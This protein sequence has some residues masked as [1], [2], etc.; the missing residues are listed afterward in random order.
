MPAKCKPN[1]QVLPALCAWLLLI[2]CTA[3]FFAC[4]SS[5]LSEKH[6]PVILI[7][8]AVVSLFV[9]VNFAMATFMDPGTFPRATE[10]E[11]K[12]GGETRAPLYKSI[13]V[14]GMSIRM[15]WCS[16]CQFY[17]PPRCS[18]C[19][20]CNACIEVFDH[21]CPWVNN[22]IGRSNYRYF[23]QFLISLTIDMFSIFAFSLLYVVSKDNRISSP[24]TV[25][26]I[27]LMVIDGVI[28]IPV[29]GLTCFHMVLISRAR[30]TNEQVTG[31]MKGGHNPFDQGCSVNFRHALCAPVWPK[32]IGRAGKTY[33]LN[34][35]QIKMVYQASLNRVHMQTNGGSK[36]NGGGTV[37]CDPSVSM[38]S[39]HSLMYPQTQ[40]LQGSVPLANGKNFLT[41]GDSYDDVPLGGSAHSL[42]TRSLVGPLGSSVGQGSITGG[43]FAPSVPPTKQRL[44]HPRLYP[45]SSTGQPDVGGASRVFSTTSKSPTGG[46]PGGRALSEYRAPI[47]S[48]EELTPSPT[49]TGTFRPPFVDENHRRRSLGTKLASPTTMRNSGVSRISEVTAVYQP[50]SGE[51]VTM[52]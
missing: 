24:N 38:D 35:D 16:T 4:A 15:K 39:S 12:S 29:I 44:Y 50:T 32:L 27:V 18:H 45:P 1:T 28:C 3:I 26:L 33:D 52:A 46:I 8:E 49:G 10:D 13:D 48:S 40:I 51:V 25:L 9:V 37:S 41:A 30:T 34:P 7:Y 5:Y 2:A 14:N 36:I 43:M 31:K 42:S 20:V 17:R 23:V 6:S 47:A 22:C 19:S 11:V 21:H